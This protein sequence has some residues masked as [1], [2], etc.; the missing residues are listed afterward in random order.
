MNEIVHKIKMILEKTPYFCCES[1]FLRGSFLSRGYKMTSDID[2]LIVSGD[3]KY[4]SYLKR[5]E[6]IKKTINE[7]NLEVSVD[8][9][10]LSVDEYKQLLYEKREMLKDERMNRII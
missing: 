8:A 6:L 7:M 2:L 5:R 9:I 4:M 3:F 10:C 1:C